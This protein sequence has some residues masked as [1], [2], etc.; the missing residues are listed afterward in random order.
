[1]SVAILILTTTVSSYE[2]GAK[3]IQMQTSSMHVVTFKL[4]TSTQ[5]ALIVVSEVSEAGKDKLQPLIDQACASLEHR[6][7]SSLSHFD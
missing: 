1:M 7:L 4:L 5:H 6:T 2:G 3:Q